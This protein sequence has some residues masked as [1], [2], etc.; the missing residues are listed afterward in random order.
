MGIGAVGVFL[1]AIVGAVVLAPRCTPSQKQI[2]AEE[3]AKVS[4][5]LRDYVQ[6][7]EYVVRF[8]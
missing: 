6:R 1:V 3:D 8:E 5:S 7:G 2:A 4:R